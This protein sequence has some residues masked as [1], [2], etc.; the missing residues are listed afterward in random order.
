MLIFHLSLKVYRAFRL[1]QP[2]SSYSQQNYVQVTL[3]SHYFSRRRNRQRK[4]IQC[5]AKHSRSRLTIQKFEWWGHLNR[6]WIEHLSITW[7]LFVHIYQRHR[8]DMKRYVWRSKTVSFL[9]CQKFEL[10][11]LQVDHGSVRANTTSC[12]ETKSQ[13]L[14]SSL[15]G[16]DK[17]VI[18]RL[19]SICIPGLSACSEL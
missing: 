4:L 9:V 11:L 15:E 14:Q 19:E 10:M 7:Y 8:I 12:L 1:Y 17:S 16:Y 5:I 18:S 3:E 6:N 13:S 2:K